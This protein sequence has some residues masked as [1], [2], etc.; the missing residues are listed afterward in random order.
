MMTK[1]KSFLGAFLPPDSNPNNN[2]QALLSVASAALMIEVLLSDYERKPEEQKTLIAIIKKSFSL[3]QATTEELLN[4]AEK[5][6]QEAT[7]Y[8]RFTSQIND[9]CTPQEKVTLIENLWRVAYADGELHHYEEHLIRR[10]ADLTHVSHMDFIAAKLRVM[11]A[12]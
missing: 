12:R 3:D 7:D 4:Q 2:S 8:F 11:D 6:Q 1:L 9:S 10:I 5:A